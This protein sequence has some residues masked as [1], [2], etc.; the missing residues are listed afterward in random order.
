MNQKFVADIAKL[1]Q[2]IVTL[3]S[4]RG[5]MSPTAQNSLNKVEALSKLLTA[6]S[7]EVTVFDDAEKAKF[8]ADT[9]ELNQAVKVLAGGPQL[10]GSDR[11]T[12]AEIQTLSQ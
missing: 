3:N 7:T 5:T 1:N 4:S 6:K 2:R 10:S 9:I 11:S 8:V 12:I